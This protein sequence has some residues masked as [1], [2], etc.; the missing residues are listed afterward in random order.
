LQKLPQFC[1]ILCKSALEKERSWR[2]SGFRQV[3]KPA[4]RCLDE[5][6]RSEPRCL[7]VFGLATINPKAAAVGAFQLR[8]WLTVSEAF[9]ASS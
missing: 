9:F 1:A 3:T 5:V 4:F 6:V 8:R 7:A 2:K